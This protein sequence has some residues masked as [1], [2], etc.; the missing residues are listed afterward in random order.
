MT[1]N[2]LGEIRAFS[3]TYAPQGWHVCDG[4]VL[5]IQQNNALFSLIGNV[6]GGDGVKTFALP[7]LRGRTMFNMGQKGNFVYHRGSKGGQET[8]GLTS[9]QIPLHTHDMEVE[10]AVGNVGLPTNILAIP[11]AAPAQGSAKINTYNTDVSQNTT[12]NPAVIGNTGS[13]Q[14]HNNM[15]PFQ[16][17][18]FCIATQGFYPP[19]P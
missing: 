9:S 13:G 16:T 7:D 19:R 18:N 5:N 12:L 11:Q 3:F 6:F 14:A 4:S 17:V 1:D 10:N 2:Y 8:T 15:Q